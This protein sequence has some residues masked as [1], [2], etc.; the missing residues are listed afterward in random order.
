MEGIKILDSFCY[1]TYLNRL[2][3]ISEKQLKDWL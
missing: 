3:K 1:D 2:S